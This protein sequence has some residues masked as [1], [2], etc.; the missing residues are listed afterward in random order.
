MAVDG[1]KGDGAF[2]TRKEEQKGGCAVLYREI[3]G[4]YGSYGGK[5]LVRLSCNLFIEISIH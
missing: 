4:Y 5:E 3:R 2:L 1:L